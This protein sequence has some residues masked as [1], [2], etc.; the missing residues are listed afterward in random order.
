LEAKVSELE[1]ICATSEH[2]RAE[3]RQLAEQAHARIVESERTAAKVVD[4]AEIRAAGIFDVAAR[5]IE[6][7]R[8][9]VVESNKKATAAD[10]ER[11][12]RAGN[13][14]TTGE[15]GTSLE[16]TE[17]RNRDRAITESAERLD[18]LRSLF[19]ERYP[20]P[21][22]DGAVLDPTGNHQDGRAG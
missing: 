4:E 9:K 1:G 2:D 12:L 6:E 21:D 15:T 20:S 8:D 7:A 10:E 13:L 22:R 5:S 11:I 14:I 18:H 3:A 17:K 16:D 19:S